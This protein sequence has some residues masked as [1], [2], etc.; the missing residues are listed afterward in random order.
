[1]SN[2]ISISDGWLLLRK[3]IGN[4]N[5]SAVSD[6]SNSDVKKLLEDAD[7]NKD[8]VV[9][10][11][12]FE[13]AC[14][15]SSDYQDLEQKYLAVFKK[16]ASLDNNAE[17]ISAEDIEAALKA[18]ED[19]EKSENTSGGGGVGGTGGAGGTGGTKTTDGLGS[20]DSTSATGDVDEK[21]NTQPE[22]QATTLATV[23]AVSISGNES[24]SELRT[25]RT[26]ELEEL[27]RKKNQ[28]ADL[29][30]DNAYVEAENAYNASAEQ[31]NASLGALADTLQQKQEAGEALSEEEQTFL[32]LQETKADLEAQVSEQNGVIDGIN[33]NISA[34][35]EA[36]SA[37]E[38]SLSGLKPPSESLKVP[39]YDPETGKQTG[40]DT[41]AY[42][43]AM[44]AYEAQ[45]AD[46]EAQ[47]AE[48][49]SELAELEQNLTD[50]ETKLAELEA[51]VSDNAKAIL[52]A[53]DSIEQA[54]ANVEE[55]DEATETLKEQI[56]DAK[57]QA[58]EF[59]NNWQ[60]L[61]NVKEKLTAQIDADIAQLRENLNAY[62]E[63]IAQKDAEQQENLPDGMYSKNGFIY[64]GEGEDAKLMLPV[65]Q[66]EDGPN[67]PKGYEINE[68]DGTIRDE[69]DAIVGK[70]IE[71]EKDANGDDVPDVVQSYYLYSE[72]VA[73]SATNERIYGDIG[74]DYSASDSFRNYL[75]TQNIDLETAT[76]DELDSALTK[77]N[78]LN[79]NKNEFIRLYNQFSNDEKLS[80]YLDDKLKLTD[81][82][83]RKGTVKQTLENLY[84]YVINV[85][86]FATEYEQSHH[87]KISTSPL[88]S[89]SISVNGDYDHD[90]EERVPSAI[91]E[92][93][94]ILNEVY[95]GMRVP[96]D[97]GNI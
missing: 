39:T 41:S 45:K 35:Q 77:Y 10:K 9:T 78:E 25:G 23:A 92:M 4:I 40:V 13:K 43:A 30:N 95:P 6:V 83:T 87:Y 32:S 49:E 64:E 60:N 94:R 50:A 24:V 46:L 82:D 90:F 75:Y 36:K 12:E 73:A 89:A 76:R 72:A 63:A 96:T 53:L 26:A 57:T 16:L 47:I 81:T 84:N 5:G 20:P 51:D 97:N 14:K 61:L 86:A 33:Q 27:N 67:L 93:K 15:E 80:K 74:S 59:F 69:N 19:A 3:M 85:G 79:R 34:T 11:D 70:I 55:V 91:E 2:N 48:K 52:N 1:M 31:Y 44:A 22:T 38:S 54:T 29:L 65:A 62:D 8:G 18:I 37:L 42:D 68:E 88:Y 58:E 21:G 7:T 28:K 56:S 17:S 71:V 66:S